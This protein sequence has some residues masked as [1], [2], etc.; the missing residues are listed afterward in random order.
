[1]KLIDFVILGIVALAMFFAFRRIRR[2]K[3]SSCSC[4]CENC[5]QACP[6]TRKK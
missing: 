5:G 3:G 6:M 1:M 2:K 4:G